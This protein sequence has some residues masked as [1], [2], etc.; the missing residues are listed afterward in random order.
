MK[1]IQY[2]RN[3]KGNKNDNS[4]VIAKFNKICHKV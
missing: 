1:I 3:D 4:Y 2:E